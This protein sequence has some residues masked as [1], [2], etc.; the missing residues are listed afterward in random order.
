MTERMRD[1]RDCLT[2]YECRDRLP[3]LAGRMDD[4][5]LKQLTIWRGERFTPGEAYFDL[6]NPARGPFVATGDEGRPVDYTYVAKAEVTEPAW[7]ALIAWGEPVTPDQA[8]ALAAQAAMFAPAAPQSAAGDAR[9]PREG[10][11]GEDPAHRGQRQRGTIARLV[12]DRGFGF[13]ASDD[14]REFFFQRAALQ[15][16]A[17]ADLSPGVPVTFVV[18]ADP[19]DEPGERPRAVSVRSEVV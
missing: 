13:I 11:G 10:E 6:D 14:G 15:G 7:A 16:V 12:T 9:E 18:G 17:F 4:D 2:A 8:E 19:G 5:T 1:L 3:A